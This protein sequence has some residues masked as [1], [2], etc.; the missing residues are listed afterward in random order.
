[1]PWKTHLG[2]YAMIPEWIFRLDLGGSALRLYGWLIVHHADW[3]DGRADPTIDQLA[4]ELNVTG[5]TIRSALAKLEASRLVAREDRP[6]KSTV[7]WLQ[8]AP[9]DEKEILTDDVPTP[10]RNLD[11]TPSKD[12]DPYP[13][14]NLSMT[15]ISTQDHIQTSVQ[16]PLPPV[17]ARN[18]D[19]DPEGFRTFWASYPRKVGKRAALDVWRKLHL[20]RIA[21]QVIAAVS[22]Q[23]TQT[24]WLRDGG[25]FIPHPQTWLRQGRWDDEPVEVPHVNE[26]TMETLTSGQAFLRSVRAKQAGPRELTDGRRNER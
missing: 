24:Q 21:S 5:P 7:Y 22:A 26:R 18:L 12:L 3:G 15:S 16:T 9:E 1:M 13:S 19:S 17:T 14:R 4:E 2:R 8:N 10:P 23:R 20:E 25:Q 11:P 6:G